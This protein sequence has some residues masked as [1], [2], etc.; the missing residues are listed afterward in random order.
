MQFKEDQEIIITFQDE[1]RDHLEEI[2]QGILELENSQEKT[3]KELVHS[4]FRSAHSIKA[5]ANLLE[6][7]NIEA[8]AHALENILTK[9]LSG[10]LRME[11]EIATVSLQGIDKMGELLENLEFSDLVNLSSLVDNLT[12][13][14][15]P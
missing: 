3:D 11:S 6:F 1:T 9:L 2:E 7:R 8:L 12:A 10:E 14:G 5:G 13:Q 15:K 4:L